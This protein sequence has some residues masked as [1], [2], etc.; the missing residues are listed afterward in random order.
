M[1]YII[2]LFS[3]LLMILN[4][5]SKNNKLSTKRNLTYFILEILQYNFCL[6]AIYVS[7]VSI[8]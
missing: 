2:E 7:F 8:A 6:Y 4:I 3:L 5:D 1:L